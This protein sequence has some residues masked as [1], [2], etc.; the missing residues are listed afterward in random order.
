M[1]SQVERNAVGPTYIGRTQIRLES[2]TC[3]WVSVATGLRG[4]EFV[5]ILVV[6]FREAWM[7][8]GCECVL[9]VLR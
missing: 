6:Y 8:H 4:F 2:R 5:L 1:Q 3:T 9:K 7:A